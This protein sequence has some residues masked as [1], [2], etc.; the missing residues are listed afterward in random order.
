MIEMSSVITRSK[1]NIVSR[2]K[3]ANERW[4]RNSDVRKIGLARN[5]GR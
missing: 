2:I 4:N 3:R 1:G 5:A